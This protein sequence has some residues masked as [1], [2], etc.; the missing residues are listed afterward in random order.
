MYIDDDHKLEFHGGILVSFLPFLSFI[1]VTVFLALNKAAKVPGMWVGAFMGIMITFFLCKNKDKYSN[2]I[3]NGMANRDAIIPIACWIFAGVFSYFLR[4]TGLVNGIIWGAYNLGATGTLF[5]LVSF[6]SAALFATASG[7][8]FGTILAAMAVLYPAGVLLGSDPYVL[9]GAIISGGAFG[10]NLAAV[11]DTSIAAATSQGVSVGDTVKARLPFSLISGAITVILIIL[12][13]SKNSATQNIPYESLAPYMDPKG[14]YMLIPAI[15]T[16]YISIKSGDIIF[17]TSTGSLV[18]MIIGVSVGLISFHDLFHIEAGIPSGLLVT[19]IGSM[20][21]ICLLALLIFICVNILKEGQGDLLLLN[22]L[23]KVVTS[24]KHVE[25][26]TLFL[27][28]IMTCMTLIIVPAILAIGPTFTKPLGEEFKVDIC[29]RANFLA[30]GSVAIA[31][32]MP[33]TVNIATAALLSEEANKLFGDSVPSL[34]V[35]QLTTHSFYPIVTF[36]VFLISALV[37][38]NK[39][40]KQ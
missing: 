2:A 29:R 35:T 30:A 32:S 5:T 27:T 25:I 15:L 21:N 6:V 10:D 26:F 31:Y 16:I 37:H 24:G 36:F 11:S 40:Q 34:L 13:S 28:S 1:L 23:K 19:S 3:I 12:L 22:K 39:L 18:S 4:S 20:L 8:G 7:T 9:A 14:L 33:W 38:K 17:A